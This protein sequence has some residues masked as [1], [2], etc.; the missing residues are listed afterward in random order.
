MPTKHTTSPSRSAVSDIPPRCSFPHHPNIIK[1]IVKI[2]K[3]L[4]TKHLIFAI[5]GLCGYKLQNPR[6]NT[7]MPSRSAVTDIPPRRSF[8]TTS[9]QLGAIDTT[10]V[11]YLYE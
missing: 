2:T 7:V 9:A 11:V 5:L 10:K 4:A 3:E 1:E 6:K 8:P